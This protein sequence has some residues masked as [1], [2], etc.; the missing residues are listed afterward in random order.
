MV[1]SRRR[2]EAWKRVMAQA[3]A[4]LG[5]LEA[6][7][8]R[9][10]SLASPLQQPVCHTHTNTYSRRA[11]IH[12]HIHI[13]IHTYTHVYTVHT[14]THTCTH[15]HTHTKTHAHTHTHTHTHKDIHTHAHENVFI[16]L[17]TCHHTTTQ[18]RNNV[19]HHKTYNKTSG[20]ITK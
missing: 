17:P 20:F 4:G 8:L 13:Y 5:G 11:T 14:H 2:R 7:M 1:W 18:P 16:W 19:K 15:T 3:A 10:L 9:R 6:A 12:T